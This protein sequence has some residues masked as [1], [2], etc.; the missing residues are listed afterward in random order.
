VVR[1]TAATERDWLVISEERLGAAL[2]L[3]EVRKLHS[4]GL[5]YLGILSDASIHEKSNNAYASLG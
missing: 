5:R 4:L 1:D 3:S 2:G